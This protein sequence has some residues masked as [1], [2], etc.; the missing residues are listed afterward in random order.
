MCNEQNQIWRTLDNG[1]LVLVAH[2]KWWIKRDTTVYMPDGGMSHVYTVAGINDQNVILP[3]H[4]ITAEEYAKGGWEERWGTDAIIIAKYKKFYSEVYNENKQ[5]CGAKESLC[6]F[7]GFFEHNGALCFVDHNGMMDGREYDDSFRSNLTGQLEFY[8][9][10]SPKVKRII[11]KEAIQRCFELDQLSDKSSFLPLFVLLPPL[12]TVL[13]MFVEIPFSILMNDVYGE[14]SKIALLSQSFFGPD[15]YKNKQL[16]VNW[17]TEENDILD[18]LS[19]LNSL[20]VVIDQLKLRHGDNDKEMDKKYQKIVHKVLRR[21]FKVPGSKKNTVLHKKIIDP[22]MMVVCNRKQIPEDLPITIIRNFVYFNKAQYKENEEYM[23]K[24]CEYAE[25]GVYAQVTSSLIQYMLK[26]VGRYKGTVKRNIAK[27]EKK[28]EKAFDKCGMNPHFRCAK[29]LAIMMAAMQ[30]F[31]NLAVEKEVITD[32]DRIALDMQTWDSLVALMFDQQNIIDNR[33][34]G[35][36]FL[37]DIKKALSD[38][39]AHLCEME[40]ESIPKVDEKYLK[41]VGWKNEEANGEFIG[42]IDSKTNDVYMDKLPI[43]T[44][45]GLLCSSTAERLPKTEIRF[46]KQIKESGGLKSFDEGSNTIKIKMPPGYEPVRQ[47]VRHINLEFDMEE[48]YD[49]DND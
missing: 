16:T 14:Y 44:I 41:Y 19:K 20:L 32:D 45:K 8:G 18:C 34:I 31:H 27:Y 37:N 43:K 40:T 21:S 23:E 22:I 46:W 36:I 10:P 4:K 6:E 28:A 39:R 3:E 48:A 26:R 13:G 47:H 1:N 30:L 38:G 12:L 5:N 29:N 49:W 11:L 25:A 15:F 7:A 2:F 17:T 9:L 35:D 24:C 42:W 33:L